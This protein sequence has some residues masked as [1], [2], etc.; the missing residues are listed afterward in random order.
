VEGYLIGGQH[1]MNKFE[2]VCQTC[3]AVTKDVNIS[4][5]IL[6]DAVLIVNCDQCGNEEMYY[7]YMRK[8]EGDY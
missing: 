8:V 6:Y 2:M 1:T 7:W 3:N 5:S 4:P